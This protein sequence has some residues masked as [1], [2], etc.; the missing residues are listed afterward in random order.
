MTNAE[1][2]CCQNGVQTL[3][4]LCMLAVFGVRRG[5]ASPAYLHI[6]YPNTKQRSRGGQEVEPSEE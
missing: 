3:G 5:G 4:V 1:C 2:P 6:A